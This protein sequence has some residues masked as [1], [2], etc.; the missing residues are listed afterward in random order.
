MSCSEGLA[1]IPGLLELPKELARLDS[2]ISFGKQRNY[3]CRDLA[4]VFISAYYHK[5]QIHINDIEIMETSKALRTRSKVCRA[6]VP[7]RSPI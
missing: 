6:V 7:V 2:V 1:E 3:D 5:L 4:M